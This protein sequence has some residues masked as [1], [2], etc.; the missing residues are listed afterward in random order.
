[1]NSQIFLIESESTIFYFLLQ[2]KQKKSEYNGNMIK[3]DN[4]TY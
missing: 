1:M 4:K 3:F 2:I